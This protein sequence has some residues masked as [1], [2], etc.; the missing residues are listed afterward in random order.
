MPLLDIHTH[1]QK[2]KEHIEILNCNAMPKEG[3]CS[4]GIHPWE[5]SAKWE[6]TIATITS[7]AR[8]KSV[9]AIGECGFDLV[10]S[11][12]TVD[13]QKEVFLKHVEISEAIE[14]PLIIHLVKGQDILLQTAKSSKHKQPWIIH[15][16]RGKP[17][18]AKQLLNAGMYLSFGEKFNPETLK[19]TPLNRLFI[20]SDESD[21]SLAEIYGS[22]A[23]CIEISIEE[24]KQHISTN[25]MRCKLSVTVL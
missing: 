8:E 1:K 18:Q 12:A 11:T 22:I 13:L 25:A 3:L 16:F 21:K 4:L 17:E 2:S 20:E 5:I 23:K 14:K 7:M 6:H 10:N 15:G 19:T 24:L 9:V